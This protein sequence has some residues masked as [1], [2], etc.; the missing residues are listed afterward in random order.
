M[1]NLVS[2][3][4]STRGIKLMFIE[5][6]LSDDNSIFKFLRGL[7]LDLFLSKPQF[8]HLTAF[9]NHMTRESYNGK[10]SNIKH[11]HRTSLSRFLNKSQWE[12]DAISMH[13]QSY[14]ISYIY[15]RSQ[16]TGQ[17]VYVSIDDTT[18]VKTE[19]S[20]QASHPIPYQWRKY[21]SHDR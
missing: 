21:D 20:S 11:R 7:D 19:P 15:N 12:C 1:Y 18:C 6:I 16:S 17:P 10:I 3:N 9:L 5:G 8:N 2:Y 13:L 14:I 4:K